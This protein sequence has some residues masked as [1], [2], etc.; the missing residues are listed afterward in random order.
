MQDRP[1]V[2]LGKEYGPYTIK[3]IIGRGGFS[4]VYRTICYDSGKEFA[5]KVESIEASKPHIEEEI[6]VMKLIDGSAY[7]PKFYHFGKT[8]S[9]KFIIMELLGPNLTRIRKSLVTSKLPLSTALRCGIEMIRCI[10]ELHRKGFVHRDIKPSNFMIKA[11]R[12]TPLALIDFG[13]CRRYI[14]TDNMEVIPPRTDGRFVGSKKYAS[15]NSHCGRELSRKDDIISWF[16]SLCEL[17][18]GKHRWDGEEDIKKIKKEL[19]YE[20]YIKA[21]FPKQ[22]FSIWRTIN[23]LKYEDCP[24]Y[25]LFISFLDDCMKDLKC[26]WY[27]PFVWET[28]DQVAIVKLSPIS[29]LPPIGDNPNVPTN[30]PPPY[31]PGEEPKQEKKGCCSIA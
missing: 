24:N 14:N 25:A 10:E 23:M 6:T 5:M 9:F 28:M 7:F 16:Y 11:S 17:V 29:L 2:R 27:E 21:N 26:T 20:E 4:D 22:F 1:D 15:I 18:A 19:N 8:S 13:L 30:L 31:V 3:D 12:S